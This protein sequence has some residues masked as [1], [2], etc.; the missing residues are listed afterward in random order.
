MAGARRAAALAVRQVRAERLPRYEIPQSRE[1]VFGEFRNR[2]LLRA[3]GPVMKGL[4]AGLSRPELSAPRPLNPNRNPNFN[5]GN[6][7][8]G[9]LRSK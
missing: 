3:A 9:A 2:T 4:W 8:R 1:G 7:N 5:A 6:G